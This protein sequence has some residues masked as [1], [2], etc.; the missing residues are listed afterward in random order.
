MR[1]LDAIA[2]QV[3][4]NRLKNMAVLQDVTDV[5]LSKAV[6]LTTKMVRTWRVRLV[7]GED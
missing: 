7:V 3:E 2:D 5:D 4:I 1:E 6:H